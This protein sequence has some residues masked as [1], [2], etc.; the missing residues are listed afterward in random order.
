MLVAWVSATPEEG[1][2]DAVLLR[3][4]VAVLRRGL[5]RGL[6]VDCVPVC[7]DAATV[8]LR[9]HA[10]ASVREV[11]Y[12]RDRAEKHTCTRRQA[13]KRTQSKVDEITRR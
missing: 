10:F 5:D 11:E 4:S 6:A 1:V 9:V 7:I 13:H 2:R 12:G 8:C 3:L